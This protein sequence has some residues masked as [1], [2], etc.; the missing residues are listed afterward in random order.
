MVCTNQE[1]FE[2]KLK[3]GREAFQAQVNRGKGQVKKEDSD[4]FAHL[5]D[6]DIAAPAA[7]S[8]AAALIKGLQFRRYEPSSSQDWKIRDE[9]AYVPATLTAVKVLLGLE[10][11]NGRSVF[12][13]EAAVKALAQADDVDVRKVI[14]NLL[15]YAIRDSGK[16]SVKEL[17]AQLSK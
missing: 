11:V 8:I 5:K 12:S 17:A 10:E 13:E 9:F 7:R 14:T 15:V 1:H 16:N 6:I 4:L 3:K 2:E